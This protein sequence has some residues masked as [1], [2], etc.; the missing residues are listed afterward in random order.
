MEKIENDMNGVII[1]DGVNA[2]RF[3][4]RNR[5]AENARMM[6]DPKTAEEGEDSDGDQQIEL[7]LRM[8]MRRNRLW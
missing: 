6:T 7:K 1:S 3:T 5:T 4:E 8:L 2:K